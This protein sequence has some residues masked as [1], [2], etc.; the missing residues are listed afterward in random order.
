MRTR[1]RSSMYKTLTSEPL[2]KLSIVD[3]TSIRKSTCVRIDMRYVMPRRCNVAPDQIV[4]PRSPIS[5]PASVRFRYSTSFKQSDLS[6]Y[7]LTFPMRYQ[8]P[9]LV[10][11]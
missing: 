10:L 6:Y 7:L 2:V 1:V 8:K 4:Q 9:F 11:C 5:I 3:A